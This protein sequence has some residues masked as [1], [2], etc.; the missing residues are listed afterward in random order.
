[1][2]IH[3]SVE[4]PV[5]RTTGDTLKDRLTE[6]AYE[7]ILPARYLRQNEEGEMVED[8][9]ELFERVAKNVALAEAVYAAERNGETVYVEPS[10]V[11][12]DHSNRDELVEEVFGEG[13]ALEDDVTT[14]L[15]E[16]NVSKFAY[17]TVV[18]KL[19]GEVREAV[20]ETRDE[21]QEAMERLS[22]IPNSPT[23][24]NAGDELQQLSACF[25]D[26]PGDDM[27]DIHETAKEAAE[28]FQC[29]T[30]DATVRVEGK[31]TVSVADVE[32]GDG[33]VQR[34]GDGHTTR[35]VDEVHAYDEAPVR[36][37]VT[38]AGTEV[39]GTPNHEL[40]IDGD[41]TRI[42]E[43]GEGDSVALRLG[44]LDNGG[45]DVELEKV[46]IGALWGESRT[47]SNED[48]EELHAEGLSDY[49]IAE[50]LGTSP[51]TVQRR[52]SIELGLDPNGTGGRSE[53]DV[54]FDTDGFERLH[55]DGH[56]DGQIADELG[57]SARTVAR[58]REQRSLDP[59]GSG[60]KTVRQPGTLTPELAE[61]VGMWVGDGSKHEDGIRFHLAR[62]ETLERADRLCRELFDAGLD[63]RWN[64]GCYDAVLHSHEVKRWWLTNFGDAKPD[65]TEA[66]VPDA[67]KSAD[68]ET[69]SAFLRGL[70]STDGG[71]QKDLYPRLWSASEELI[72]G[73]QNL[74]LGIGVPAVRWG[75]D[76]DERD[77][78][79]VG[80]TGETGLKNF[81]E[82]IGFVGSR[83][84]TMRDEFGSV[85]S[86]ETTVGSIEGSTWQ[87]PVETVEDA[88]TDTVYD[89][90]VADEPEYVANSIVSHNSGG[91]MGY[92]F[93]KLRPYGDPV[94]STGGI[95][96]GPITFMRTFDQMCQTVAQGG[97]RRGA[98]MGVMRVSHPDVI[99]FIHAKNKDV[100]L[101]HTLRLNDP[102]DY[103]HTS[104]TEA[105][106]E[107]RELIDDDGRVPQHLRNAAEGHLS[108]F[109]IS[110]G[111]SHD[112]MEALEN[113]EE[114][115]FTNPRTDEPHV[116]TE[117]TKEIY[118]RFGLGDHVEVG[119]VLSVPA[120][121]VWQRMIEGAYENGEP[122]VIYLDR[123]N[124]EHSFDVEEHPDHEMLATNPCVTGDTLISTENGLVPAEELYETGVATDVVVD[125]R[126]T[127][128]KVKE[129]SS[130]YKTGEKDVYRLTTEEG[131]EI[132]LTADHRVMTDEGWKEAGSLDEGAT[133]HI[134]NRKGKF[135][136]HGTPAEGRVLGW[137]VG[138]GHLKHGE[139]RAVLNF[140][141]EDA[142]VSEAFAE[143]VN[144]VVREP[145]GNA[146][147][148]VGVS[149]I[150]RG[151]DYRGEG[152][153]EQ[154]IRSARLYEVAEEAG[155]VKDKH[156]VPDAVTRGSEGMARGFLRALFTAD[157]GVQGNV[158]KGVSVRLTS[159][160]TELLRDVQRLLLNF[161]VFSKIYEG[162]HEAGSK[163]LP[164][165]NGGT[166]EYETQA[167][168]DLV[169]SKDSLVRFRGEIGF[170]LDRKNE[171]LD[172]RLAE[173]D[174][175]PYADSFDATVESVEYDGHEAVYD[176]TEPDTH[177]F[178]GNGVV[179]HN[180]GEQPLEEYEACNL[181]HINLSTLVARDAPDWRDWYADN[182]DS[183]AS[184]ED[185]VDAFLDEAIDWGEFDDRIET[186][187]RFL[188]NVVTMS[189]FPIDEIEEKV[190]EMRKIGLGIMGLA[191]MYVQTG[192]RYGSDEANEVAR[193]VMRYI[194]HGSKRTS[195]ELADERG[196]FDEWDKSK[197]ANPTEYADWFEKQTG[198]SADD[199]EDGYPVRNH[200]TTTIAPTGCVDEDS[201]VST[202]EGLCR[203]KSLDN[204]GAEFD[205][206]GEIDEAVA[207]DGGTKAATAVY[208]NGF[209]DVR[210]IRTEGGF[211]VAA[212]PNHRFR[213]LTE[214]GEYTWK[215]ADDFKPGDRIVLQRDTFEGGSRA[216]LDTTER[217]NYYRN[218]DPDLKLPDE[219]SSELAEFLGYFMGDG[220]VHDDVGVKL[221]VE[222]DAE[223]I[224]EYL[225][226]LGESVFG[227]T[228]TVEDRGT[229]HVLIF[230]G[231]HLPRY[232]DDN[233]W[234]KEDGNNG[235]GAAS[236]FVPD[237]VL[238][239][240]EGCAK[241]F[242]RGLFEADGTAS[243]KVEL[244]TVSSKLA[245]QVQTLLL[246][247][248]CVFVQDV[249]ETEGME[250]HYGDR[251][252]YSVRG[253]NKREDKRFLDKIGF[254]TK[255]TEIKLTSQSY[256]RDSYPPA[257][258]DHLRDLSGYDDVSEETKHR[259]RQSPINGSVT[260][261]LVRDVEE[262]TGEKVH[263]DG[264]RLND[265]YAAPV[266]SVTEETAYTKDI[267]VP[268]NNTYVAN[269]FVTHNTTSMIGNTTGGCEPIYNV[270]YY[271]N[272]SDD[273][274]GDE[275]LV[276]FDDYF[277]RVLREND[278]D[279]EAV[280]E[281]A[282]EQMSANEFDGVDGLD[283]VP[284][285]IGELFVTTGDLSAKEHASVQC[286]CQEGV[287]SAISKTTNAP[288]DSTVE[289][290]KEVFEYIYRNGGKGVTYYRDG[291]RSKQVLTTRA[292]N[293]DAADDVDPVEEVRGMLADGEL[294]VDEL[295]DGVEGI[296]TSDADTPEATAGAQSGGEADG[297]EPTA[298]EDAT[299]G[300]AEAEPP[301][302][303]DEFAPRPR[304]DTISGATQKVETG[305][306]GL[307]VTINEDDEG[308]FEVFARIGKSGGYTASFTEAI[309]RLSSL[310]LR[311]GIPPQQ[312]VQQLEGI[313]S[314]KV[315]FD[316]GEQ[317]HS[318]PDGIAKAMTR[319]MNGET[320]PQ[321]S[322][323]PLREEDDDEEPRAESDGGTAT[324]SG[325]DVQQIIDE[326]RNP[327]CPDCGSMLVYTEGC[328]KCNDC[329]FSEC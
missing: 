320:R 140:Y 30:Q 104:F 197:Y 96:S 316:R 186:G 129:A 138:D 9:E 196:V 166:K 13:V 272:V 39:T 291:T 56:T 64:D 323:L 128:A 250:N 35:N 12:T 114:F 137:L 284:D 241:S 158:E 308:V 75:Y 26:S 238:G 322:R 233:G 70:F 116:A 135:G 276:E 83:D 157:G 209:A 97:T 239:S 141:D 231:R 222:S 98:Q 51:S 88:G 81:I 2:S 49:A 318:V 99:Q 263:V 82:D 306:G 201:L 242:L 122:G 220:Y 1:M 175:E 317:V 285:A 60:V 23:L 325:G 115:T 261:K 202:D 170:L 277:L 228:P 100:S 235:E 164:D 34:D 303:G 90:T 163:E 22:F 159:T 38:E 212:T 309:A 292:D 41:W 40:L 311:S 153:L 92:A 286:A 69:V 145:T 24:M 55:G 245:E 310:C 162:R 200:N 50:T 207:T 273:V 76:T 67:V 87:V 172:D 189:D 248:D 198:E 36:R 184:L 103:T 253:A 16:E 84:Q 144:E 179:V 139:E 283:T 234:K 27:Q 8:Q 287:D 148:G 249:L 78:Y 193:Q 19:E 102:D 227:V 53:G 313:R 295:T 244:S 85:D 94:G 118:E 117:G 264:R 46:E 71:L 160:D 216:T 58:Y 315:T 11:K 31:G 143:D 33:I 191:Q 294:T 173:Y 65:A 62:D 29:L 278:I 142:E 217:E 68:T 151:D 107:A 95:A 180:C 44:W 304:P 289:D 108:N 312:V 319:Y 183:Y 93:W 246:S 206:W 214:D 185:A 131:Y 229:R 154:R 329:G 181:G 174:R 136:N 127:D 218:T 66:R 42:D 3:N 123:V 256:K 161:G 293:K 302:R 243:R 91:G 288:H 156:A 89:V 240:D 20:V 133:V 47:V 109:N 106:D 80:P 265:F 314:P 259:V 168:H 252:R 247:L 57:V 15:T 14:Q 21:F 327:E 299:N 301:K 5:K 190:S 74:L 79:N 119:E 324:A 223:E 7:R 150:A 257:V 296:D 149:E 176:L 43:V 300:T 260:R 146:D 105:L 326:G 269:G 271:K 305:Y 237:E 203:I 110:V 298:T 126:L 270:A 59:N 219:M 225:R 268:S 134:Q 37:L 72:D 328:V 211:S 255:T 194:N 279:V 52:R 192:I 208:D 232:F 321:Q 18:P 254:I 290:A 48:I 147:Y 169:V 32:P 224:D 226:E 213:T 86:E 205:Q 25:V 155:L 4:L 45:T 132:R 125:G 171:E 236:A 267:S 262:E 61:L 6:N 178:I 177:S 77:Y 221:V 251:P 282:Q 230:G 204:T 215:E 28:V 188:E 266:K 121:E 130:V 182:G 165:G 187:T 258:A 210:R 195:H 111:V 307:Y 10:D 73:V 274:Q 280:K 167:D 124:D 281:E 120:N 63:R 101:A 275:M 113:D 199:W 54:G 297:T 112:F 152:A 17:D